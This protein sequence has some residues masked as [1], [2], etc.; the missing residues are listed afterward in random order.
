M[1]ISD[2]DK[3]DWLGEGCIK[4]VRKVDHN[5]SKKVLPGFHDRFSADLGSVC[6]KTE[7]SRCLLTAEGF[8]LIC[9]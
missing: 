5:L 3:T 2:G 8:R 9:I 4:S 7:S 6:T 1:I